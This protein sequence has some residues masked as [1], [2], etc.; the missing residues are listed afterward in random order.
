[1]VPK[2]DCSGTDGASECE[3]AARHERQAPPVCPCQSALALEFHAVRV[4]TLLKLTRHSRLGFDARAFDF[5]FAHG[6]EPRLFFTVQARTFRELLL[7]N[8]YGFG[9]LA[10]KPFGRLDALTFPALLML[11]FGIV[12]A[13]HALTLLAHERFQ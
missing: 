1:M 5:R 13:L 4:F 11:E 6:Q 8:A 12:L 7:T 9:S 10:G 2:V 3:H